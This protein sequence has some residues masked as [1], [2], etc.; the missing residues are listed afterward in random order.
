MAQDGDSFTNFQA[1]AASYGNFNI[2]DFGLGGQLGSGSTPPDSPDWMQSMDIAE[3]VV[4]TN[5]L[6]ASD[7]A[8]VFNYLT[9]KWLVNSTTNWYAATLS[10]AVSSTFAVSQAPVTITS[11]LSAGDKYYDEIGRAHV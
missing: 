4:Y 3:V 2:S 7:S 10:N 9:N 8:V 5:M 1:V 6:T 11:G